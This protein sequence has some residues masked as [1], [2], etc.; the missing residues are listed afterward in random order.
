[1]PMVNLP[2]DRPK[3]P[4]YTARGRRT[5]DSLGFAPVEAVTDP[6]DSLQVAGL[7]GV[8]F[9]FPALM[10]DMAFQRAL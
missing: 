3:T 1:M 2:G 6:K 5:P 9:D 7:G 8:R 10:P 4:G